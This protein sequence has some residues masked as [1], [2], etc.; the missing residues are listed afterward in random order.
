M[1]RC[2]R[3]DPLTLD[4]ELI[5][6]QNTCLCACT[7]KS[8][9]SGFQLLLTQVSLKTEPKMTNRLSLFAVVSVHPAGAE[10]RI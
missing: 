5:Q 10:F 4:Y 1:V 3:V 8:E 6:R 9:G 2:N 7:L